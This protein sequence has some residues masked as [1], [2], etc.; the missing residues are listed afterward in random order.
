MRLFMH[1][2]APH[3]RACSE[4]IAGSSCIHAKLLEDTGPHVCATPSG[5]FPSNRVWC[6]SDFGA[7]SFVLGA[8]RGREHDMVSRPTCD[9]RRKISKTA[10]HTS[11][12][13]MHGL[14][15]GT[16]RHPACCTGS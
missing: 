7:R 6:G 3:F 12:R 2:P 11:G 13:F 5:A 4:A 1:G 9:L 15:A 10:S 14:C 16:A 8:W